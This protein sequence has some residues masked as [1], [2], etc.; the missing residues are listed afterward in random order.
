MPQQ[1]RA[2]VEAIGEHYA[3]YDRA[4]RRCLVVLG[5]SV[6]SDP[7]QGVLAV[8]VGELQAPLTRMFEDIVTRYHLRGV[9]AAELYAVTVRAL[10]LAGQA[11]MVQ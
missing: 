4:R 5:G 10:G 9:S 8:P 2:T 11:S 3:A 7:E 6:V 1:W